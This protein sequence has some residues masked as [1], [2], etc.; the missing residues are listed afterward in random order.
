MKRD[1]NGRLSARARSTMADRVRGIALELLRDTHPHHAGRPVANDLDVGLHHTDAQAAAG[2]T[3]RTDARFPFGNARHE[4]VVGHEANQLVL[5][6][7]AAGERR[8][9][10]GDGRQLDEGPSVHQK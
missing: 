1:L 3:Q 10:A 8:A 4:L 7:A 2:A 9:G 6:V 5:G